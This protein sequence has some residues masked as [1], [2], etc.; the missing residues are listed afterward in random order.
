MPVE[1]FLAGNYLERADVVLTRRNWDLTSWAIRWATNSPFSHAAMVFTGPQF[2]SGYSNTFVIESSYQRRRPDEPA[3]LHRGQERL[4]CHQAF[5]E[6]LV[7]RDQAGARARPAARQ[8]QVQLQLLGHR[9]HHAQ[10]VVRGSGDRAGREGRPIATIAARARGRRP[11]SSSAPASCRSASSKPCSNTSRRGSFR[12]PPSTTS[13]SSPR[14]RQGFRHKADWAY[15]DPE[16]S[17]TTAVLFRKQNYEALQWVTPEDLASSDKLEWLYFIKDGL[18]YKV[19]TYD[20]VKKL[21]AD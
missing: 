20:E 12:P 21:S 17:K 2:E 9:A 13:C 14:R 10:S 18:V 5:Q 3:R 7:R 19:S 6:G 11:T 15:L 16:S 8:D 1:D 4:P